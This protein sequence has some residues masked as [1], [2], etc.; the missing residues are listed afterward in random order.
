MT[1]NQKQ[2]IKVLRESGESY[3]RISRMTGLPVNSIKTYCRRN[4]LQGANAEKNNETSACRYCGKAIEQNPGRKE[5]LL[6][7][8]QDAL[9]ELPHEPGEP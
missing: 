9:V 7:Q 6:G 2:Q 5:V 1:D 8:M 3:A 4:N